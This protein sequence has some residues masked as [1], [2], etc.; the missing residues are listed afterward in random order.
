MERFG[1]GPVQYG[2]TLSCCNLRKRTVTLFSAEKTQTGI[3]LYVLFLVSVAAGSLLK[4]LAPEPD[5][6]TQVAV[7][8]Y[9]TGPLLL[10]CALAAL[11]SPLAGLL[12]DYVGHKR[13]LSFSVILSLI[14]TL[15]LGAVAG[16]VT[17]P[18][19]SPML[20][21]FG[22]LSCICYVSALSAAYV[23][24]ATFTQHPIAAKFSLALAA[25]AFH[26]GVALAVGLHSNAVKQPLIE[27]F[28]AGAPGLGQPD[29]VLG[30]LLA[31]AALAAALFAV[32]FIRKNR[33]LKDHPA[34]LQSVRRPAWLRLAVFAAFASFAWAVPFAALYTLPEAA[35]RTAD[36]TLPLAEL[37]AALFATSG[38]LGPPLQVALSGANPF[39][40]I[41]AGGLGTALPV[42]L[43]MAPRAA[44]AITAP[45]FLAFAALFHAVWWPRMLAY[46]CE[47]SIYGFHAGAFLGMALSSV[48]LGALIAYSIGPA[49]IDAFCTH[50]TSCPSTV[51]WGL[52]LGIFTTPLILNAALHK[53]LRDKS[54]VSHWRKYLRLPVVGDEELDDIRLSD[55]S[56]SDE[57]S[58]ALEST[59]GNPF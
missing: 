7:G 50:A 25:G 36:L 21:I 26:L 37:G 19:S 38:L 18:G 56:H 23:A 24:I 10:W 9:R 35:A 31:T 40:V 46:A 27:A 22:A 3:A 45:I 6:L 12:V 51:L 2:R 43:L 1:S 42:A 8:G 52:H 39:V 55:S 53:L 48:W 11:V 41:Y 32:P 29:T 4:T 54:V 15:L 58:V 17:G 20:W 47:A 49:L 13:V 44:W 34:R 28:V 59:A 16:L 30:T 33:H 14:A 5:F 57:P